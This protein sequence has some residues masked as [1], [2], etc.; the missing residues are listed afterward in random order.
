MPATMLL[1]SPFENVWNSSLWASTQLGMEGKAI[2]ER[3]A[4][5]AALGKNAEEPVWASRR[6]IA[7]RLGYQVTQTTITRRLSVMASLGL[8]TLRN[9]RKGLYTVHMLTDEQVEG[10]EA[11]LGTREKVS[12]RERDAK[13]ESLAYAEWTWEWDEA[14]ELLAGVG[15][16]SNPCNL[17]QYT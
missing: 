16:V 6:Y 4:S 5:L 8:V 2:Y 9:K 17:N 13:L 7:S 14:D 12:E 15:P 10:L 11:F 1:G 3:L